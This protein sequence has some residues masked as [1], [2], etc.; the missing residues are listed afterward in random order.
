MHEE[1]VGQHVADGS[2]FVVGGFFGSWT[3][4]E[5]KKEREGNREKGWQLECFW[6]LGLGRVLFWPL[7]GLQEIGLGPFWVGPLDV[8]AVVGWHVKSME[9]QL[10]W[11][12][13]P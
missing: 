3:G 2:V 12:W 7:N 11:K 4:R 1:G 13:A 8:V 5:R 9:L 6:L 10:G